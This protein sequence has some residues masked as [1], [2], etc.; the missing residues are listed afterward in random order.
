MN[1]V[2]K[3]LAESVNGTSI[4]SHK[5]INPKRVKVDLSSMTDESR[6]KNNL[7]MHKKGITTSKSKE[8]RHM[9]LY[10]VT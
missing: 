2:K 3:K 10:L 9:I 8:G 1:I 7:R 6:V 4:K 5:K